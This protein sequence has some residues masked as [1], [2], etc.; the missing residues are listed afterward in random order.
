VFVETEAVADT[1]CTEDDCVEEVFIYRVAVAEGFAG[2]EEEGYVDALFGAR[3]AE[4]EEF[5]GEVG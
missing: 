4:P 1:S 2:M 3:F 5:W